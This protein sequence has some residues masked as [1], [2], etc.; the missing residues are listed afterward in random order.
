[1]KVAPIVN[2]PEWLAIAWTFE[3]LREVPGAPT[4]PTI[5]RWLEEL[6][7]WWRD[8]ETPWCGVAMAAWMRAAGQPIPREWYRAR[9]WLGWGSPI[10]RAA[11]GAVVVIDRKGGA[12]VGLVV[13]EDA[14]GNL[15]VLG[16]N[17][18]D[19]V[20]VRAFPRNRVMGYRWPP[21]APANWAQRLQNDLPMVAGRVAIST[22]EA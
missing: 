13:G 4:A 9:A 3:G 8:D 7:A 15:Q 16:G 20:S 1:M 17:Q 6:R 19:A 5:R 18:G 22:S 14:D 21:R 12:H 10:A 11:V 2:E